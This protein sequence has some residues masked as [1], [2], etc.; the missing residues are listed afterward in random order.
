M[1]RT[2]ALSNKRKGVVDPVSKAPLMKSRKTH[3]LEDRLSNLPD[4][5]LVSIVSRLKL[6]QQA[7]TSVL[8]RSWRHLWTFTISLK[9]AIRKRIKFYPDRGYVKLDVGNSSSG[10]VNHVL[11]LHRGETIPEMS[12][13]FSLHDESFKHVVDDWI[14]FAF[15]K[16]VKRLELDFSRGWLNGRQTYLFNAKSL[17]NYRLDSLLSLNICGATVTGEDLEYILSACP[18]LEELAVSCSRSLVNFTI[19]GRSLKLKYLE[20]Y[21]HYLK[22]LNIHDVNLVAFKYGG[23]KTSISFKNTLCLVNAAFSG[24][25]ASYVAKKP[26]KV[27]S[28]LPQLEAL[29]LDL[30]WYFENLRGFPEFPMLRNLRELELR[31]NGLV[32]SLRPCI[33]LLRASPLLSRF[34][35]K[36][37][38]LRETKEEVKRLQR[39]HEHPHKFLQVFE[40]IGFVGCEADLGIA[41]YILGSAVA[42]EKIIIDTRQPDKLFPQDPDDQ[43]VARAHAR[44]RARQ[45]LE[46]SLTLGTKLVVR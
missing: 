32:S 16:R 5:I 13:K 19:T 31:L 2:S 44:A 11:E 12:I 23:P 29:S 43:K 10:W 40:L 8:A 1:A 9:F 46:T 38:D 14:S 42:L 35:I 28:S 33:S 18:F 36:F 37:L 45:H 27:I 41:W 15:Q 24:Q 34:R 30:C 25:Y 6:K 39:G 20:I 17:Q 7:R 22:S 3:C 26:I 21:T 4:E